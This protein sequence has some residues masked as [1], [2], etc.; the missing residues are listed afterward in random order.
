[1]KKWASRASG[2]STNTIRKFSH[3]ERT[4]CISAGSDVLGRGLQKKS[5]VCPEPISVSQD[6]TLVVIKA[7][8]TE[9]AGVVWPQLAEKFPYACAHWLLCKGM[10]K[11]I[12]REKVRKACFEQ[13]K[14]NKKL[15][16]PISSQA[17][18]YALTGKQGLSAH[19]SGRQ[20][21]WKTSQMPWPHS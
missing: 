17:D 10:G 4:S 14:Q 19:K 6:F 11:I 12:K 5:S 3:W 13:A 20:I 21:P 1:M 18:D 16:H 15:V 7:K 9:A 8:G 2:S